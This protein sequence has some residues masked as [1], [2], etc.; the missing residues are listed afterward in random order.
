MRRL[1]H[2]EA[3]RGAMTTEYRAWRNMR[4]RCT[5]PSHPEYKRYGARGIKVCPE[6]RSYEQFIV[7]MG[8]CPKGHSLERVDNDGDYEAGNCRWATK[9]EQMANTRVTRWIEYK[10]ERR[11]LAEWARYFGM[12]RMGFKHH[13]LARGEQGAIE[14][15]LTRRQ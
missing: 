6:W 10:G 2:G 11:M 14:Y 15:L 13:L 7:D 4:N 8:R 12:T 5:S 1:R 3:R 9:L